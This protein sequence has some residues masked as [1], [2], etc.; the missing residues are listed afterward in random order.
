MSPSARLKP[1]MSLTALNRPVLLGSSVAHEGRLW[2]I[3][4]RLLI[5]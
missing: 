3:T 1:S 2:D 4:A 5:F